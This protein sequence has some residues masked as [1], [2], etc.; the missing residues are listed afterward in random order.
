MVHAL[1]FGFTGIL[2]SA[3]TKNFEQ[4]EKYAKS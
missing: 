1:H 4:K 3:R 2:L